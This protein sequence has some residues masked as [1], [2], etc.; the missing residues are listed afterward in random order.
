MFK[1]VL[2][3]LMVVLFF[4]GFGVGTVVNSLLFLKKKTNRWGE[5][6]NRGKNYNRKKNVSVVFFYLIIIWFHCTL[7]FY[8]NKKNSFVFS[9]LSLFVVLKLGFFVTVLTVKK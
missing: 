8:C 9:P 6:Y 5:K 3:L 2:I 7:E 4:A 1:I